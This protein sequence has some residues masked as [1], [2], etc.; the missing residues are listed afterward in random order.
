MFKSKKTN[1]IQT[2]ATVKSCTYLMTVSGLGGGNV[3]AIEVFVDELNMT[4]KT[5]YKVTGI[6]AIRKAGYAGPC[7]AGDKV[8]IS[9]DEK[10]PNNFSIES[11]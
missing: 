11:F 8:T 1:R 7:K 3:F 4:L 2:T 5:N 6:D 9:Y 10:N